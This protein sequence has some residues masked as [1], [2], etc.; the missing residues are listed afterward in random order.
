MFGNKSAFGTTNTGGGFGGFGSTST[1]GGGGAFGGTSAFG[2]NTAAS[3]PSFGGFGATTTTSGSGLFNNPSSG[4]AG[5]LFGQ[6]APNPGTSTFGGF[7]ASNSGSTF[8]NSFNKPAGFGT[9]FGAATT[10]TGAAGGLF[11]S[12]TTN[13][14][15]GSL[16][17]SSFGAAPATSNASSFS[18]FGASSFGAPQ[19]QQQAGTTVKFNPPSGTDTMLK[20]GITHNISTRH[21]CISCMK[22]YEAKSLEELRFEDYAAGRKGAAGGAAPAM[23]LFGQQQQPQQQPQ[24]NA[25]PLFGSQATTQSSLFGQQQQQQQQ[26]TQQQQQ[27]KPLFGS[28]NTAGFGANNTFG[29]SNTFGQ[30]NATAAGGLFKPPN[31]FGS[32]TSASTGFGFNTTTSTSGGTLFGQQNKPAFGQPAQGGGLFSNTAGGFGTP[33]VV[34]TAPAFGQTTTAP[35]GQPLQQQQQQTGM[36]GQ[37]GVK[38]AGFGTPSTGFGAAGTASSGFGG[39]GA[40]STPSTAFGQGAKPAFG[41]GATAT[42]VASSATAPAFGFGAATSAATGG[43]LFSQKPGGGSTFSF[44]AGQPTTTGFGAGTN[45]F[46]S[47]AGGLFG[48]TQNKPGGLFGSTPS[49]GTGTAFG[50][51]SGFGGT[52]SFNL[53]GAPGTAFGGLGT[54]PGVGGMQPFGANMANG[55]VGA[56]MNQAPS[57]IIHQSLA[58]LSANPYGE[59]SLFK[60]MLQTSGKREEIIKPSNPSTQKTINSES[61]H[62][63]LSPHRNVKAKAKPLLGSGNKSSMFDGLEDDDINPKNEIFVPRASV[64]KLVLKPKNASLNT[65]QHSNIAASTNDGGEDENGLSLTMPL[66]KSSQEASFA[67]SPIVSNSNNV[68]IVDESFTALNTRNKNRKNLDASVFEDVAGNSVPTSVTTDDEGFARDGSPQGQDSSPH[69]AG[70]VLNRNGYYTIPAMSELG[71]LVDGDGN[72]FIEGFT[73]GRNGY[74]NIYFPGVMNIVGMNF[75]EIVFIRHKEVTVYPDD[76]K[77]PALGDGLNRKAQVTLDKVW[78]IDKAKR[79]PISDP[80]RLLAMNYEDRLEKASIKLDARFVEYRPE[81]GS[82]VFKVDHFSKYGLDDSDEED[83]AP[84]LIVK[85]SIDPNKKL[86]TLQLELRD[87]GSNLNT[88]GNNKM[89]ANLN[90]ANLIRNNE[91]SIDE[92]IMKR[93]TSTSILDDGLNISKNNGVS[94][95]HK[96]GLVSPMSQQ[97]VTINAQNDKVQM[98]KASLF[99]EDDEED[100]DTEMM[101]LETANESLQPKSRP[102]ILEQRTPSEVAPPLSHSMIARGLGGSFSMDQ[103][104]HNLSSSLLRN[105]ILSQ[106]ASKKEVIPTKSSST[107]N[108]NASLNYSLT[109]G[110]DNFVTLPSSGSSDRCKTIVPKFYNKVPLS[111]SLLL[112]KYFIADTGSFMNRSFR[113]GWGPEWKIVNCGSSLDSIQASL[114][115]VHAPFD[116][117]VERFSN[118]FKRN[119]E[120]IK[121]LESWLSTSLENSEIFYGENGIP[122]FTSVDGVDTLNS[123]VKEANAQF[124]SYDSAS[125]EFAKELKQAKEVWSLC[126]ALWGDLDENMNELDSDSHKITMQ[127]RQALS[128]WLELAISSE[129]KDLLEDKMDTCTKDTSSMGRILNLLTANKI[130]EACD[131]CHEDGNHFSALLMSQFG[132]G[133][134]GSLVFNQM[135]RWQEAHTDRFI[136]KDM[137]RFFALVAGNPYWPASDGKTINTCE[138]LDWKCAFSY[139]LWYLCSPVASISDALTLYINAFEGHTEFGVY[140]SA[141]FPQYSGVDD[142]SAYD[143]AYHLLRLYCD[144]SHSLESLLSPITHSKD[145]LDFRLSWFINQAL[146]SL[147]YKHLNTIRQDDLTASFASQLENLSLWEWSVFVLLHLS[148]GPKRESLIK[149]VICRGIRSCKDLDSKE[150][151]LKEKLSI[152]TEWIADGKANWAAANCQ[153]MDQSWYLLKAKRWNLAHEVLIKRIAPD[154]IINE[155]YD[156]LYK[157]LDELAENDPD[158]HV[159]GWGLSGQIFFDFINVDRDVNILK[160][161]RDDSS[162][163]FFIEKLKPKVISLCSRISKLRTETAKERLCQSEIAKRMAYLMRAVLTADFSNGGETS[164]AMASRILAETLTQLPL[165]DDYALHELRNLTKNYMLEIMEH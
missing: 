81:T 38:P 155:D 139:H 97:L 3:T 123:Y 25:T 103:S 86:K 53:G 2:Q 149:D 83:N 67:M 125:S 105:Q 126:E 110:Y 47:S 55:G 11:S 88:N 74:G 85:T 78:P 51:T 79:Q 108:K 50:A 31:A 133:V 143:I 160:E 151:F 62:H 164:K 148:H 45:A 115:S 158:T 5:G 120:V 119:E 136:E 140:A 124:D 121:C 93:H 4:A 129:K 84:P 23:G 92:E 61:A 36:F 19:Q 52:S 163:T 94:P 24:Q 137:L 117:T 54:N 134:A 147:G 71:S 142:G 75:D 154:A 150:E 16:F 161:K 102:I 146:I 9:T 165:P 144:R 99:D 69:P 32:T 145:P 13:N 49:V 76:E 8:G 80:N 152:P 41:F 106:L 96:D 95:N 68:S 107:N 138:D 116:V 48:N 153:F 156:F 130:I 112:E 132:G 43:G 131:Q 63:K 70:I 6:T 1:G 91:L 82:W 159:T 58:S 104:G 100:I 17:G 35:F 7:G 22:D 56:G 90:E 29:A 20:S 98:M 157:V 111:D 44:G 66:S 34:S 64:K 127:R 30:T 39:F 77:K 18:S 59:N 33:A 72:C 57:N 122:F 113:C 128:R 73:I 135:D 28:T 26:Q 114:D 46:G 87:Q 40:T 27:N 118:L 12:S 42:P 109:K 21:Q 14:A 162:I 89:V 37:M 15:G 10:S 60:T 65:P 101:P 141:P